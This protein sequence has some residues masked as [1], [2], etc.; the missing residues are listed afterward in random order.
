MSR[1]TLLVSLV[2]LAA[3][4][5]FPTHA[6]PVV[7][8]FEDFLPSPDLVGVV[9]NGYA[10]FN[11]D[12]GAIPAYWIS[13]DYLTLISGTNNGLNSTFDGNVGIATA[14]EASIGMGGGGVFDLVSMR[15]GSCW[16]DDQWTH[17][18]GYL[19]GTQ[20][21]SAYLLAPYGGSTFTFNWSGIDSFIL[22]ADLSTG[23]QHPG[24]PSSQHIL[25][26][27]DITLD[28]S[29]PEPSSLALVGSGLAILLLRRRRGA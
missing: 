20:V 11:W 19:G 14:Y 13:Q 2:L 7:I 17:V 28:E 25:G 8:T 27:D 18:Y 21:D 9:P 29:V 4:L 24:T 16:T 1:H 5:S 6:A 10:G 3:L 15:L 26:A 22:Q 23:T 12:A